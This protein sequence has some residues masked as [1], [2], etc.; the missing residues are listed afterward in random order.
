M[1]EQSKIKI[2]ISSHKPTEFVKN[3]LFVPVQVG[4]ELKG[5]RLPG[6]AYDNDGESISEKNLR[7]CELTAQTKIWL[8]ST[9]LV[10][11]PPPVVQ[12]PMK[13]TQRRKGVALAHSFGSQ[14]RTVLPNRQEVVK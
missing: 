8:R 13:K 5:G 2:F 9:L 12:Y 11:F 10:A 1:S 7:F 14:P 6:F 3:D 4:C